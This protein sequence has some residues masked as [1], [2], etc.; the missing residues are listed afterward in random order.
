MID[1]GREVPVNQIIETAEKYGVDI[2]ATSALLTTTLTEQK[3]LEIML[4]DLGLRDKYTTMVGGA[5]CTPRWTKRIGADIY[6]ED[7]IEAVK[8][9]RAAIDKRRKK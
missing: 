8:A 1:L 4:R 3:K 5:P 6:S 9:A 7:A 2:I